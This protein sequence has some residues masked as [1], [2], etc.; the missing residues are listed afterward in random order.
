MGTR[1]EA[2]KGNEAPA[3][4]LNT[5]NELLQASRGPPCDPSSRKV[6]RYKKSKRRAEHGTTQIQ[7]T[8]KQRT[9]QCTAGQTKNRS[10]N[11]CDHGKH[12]EGYVADRPQTPSAPIPLLSIAALI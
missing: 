4:L 11:E 7:N 3:F 9:K 6:A 1:N 8:P 5:F 10:R 12:V 2:H